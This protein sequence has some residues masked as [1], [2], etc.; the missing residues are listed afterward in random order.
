MKDR[1]KAANS[2]AL[3]VL[4]RITQFGQVNMLI[5]R[6]KSSH[7]DQD[8]TWNCTPASFIFEIFPK[9]H[10]TNITTNI[11][12]PSSYRAQPAV[13]CRDLPVR[14]RWFLLVE[15]EIDI[16]HLLPGCILSGPWMFQIN[17]S[18]LKFV[19]QRAITKM[20]SAQCKQWIAH[21]A[22][23]GRWYLV[24]SFS[25]CHL[26]GVSMRD[27]SWCITTG[28]IIPEWIIH[29]CRHPW[30][31]SAWNCLNEFHSSDDSCLS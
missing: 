23:A 31:Q 1:L 24:V 12:K 30:I 22:C 21:D 18:C 16:S 26:S 11:H 27:A 19:K 8:E 6:Q 28:V 3:A 2:L 15:D 14:S 10:T 5:N 25:R 7:L 17:L 13:T 29:T 9:H 4:L 20:L